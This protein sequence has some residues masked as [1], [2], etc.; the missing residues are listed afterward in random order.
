[1]SYYG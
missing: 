1:M